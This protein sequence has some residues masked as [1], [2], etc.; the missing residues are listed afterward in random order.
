MHLTF[1]Y[2]NLIPPII[3]LVVALKLHQRQ[4]LPKLLL[5]G[6]VLVPLLGILPILFHYAGAERVD[7]MLSSV[8]PEANSPNGPGQFG[9]GNFDGIEVG[10]LYFFVWRLAL[11]I[12][13]IGTFL[14]GLGIFKYSKSEAPLYQTHQPLSGHDDTV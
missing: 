14:L 2:G 11:S 12:S 5:S 13:G 3:L 6:I 10:P 1:L 8:F 7:A 4:K 9:G